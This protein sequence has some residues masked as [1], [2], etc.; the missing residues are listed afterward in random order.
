M[1]SKAAM[2]VEALCYKGGA[3]MLATACPRSVTS[4]LIVNR[5]RQ[6]G[7]SFNTII[8]GGA[9]I[10]QFARAAHV[11]YPQAT[12]LSFEPLPDVAEMLRAN[13]SDVREHRIFQ[14]ALGARDGETDFHRNSYNQSSSVL[15][16]LHNT[17][18]LLDGNKE[19]EHFKVSL[20][21]LDTALADV[22]LKSPVLLKLNLQG[23]ELEALRGAEVT[24]GN[25]DHIVLET[26]FEREYDGEP[27]FE[28]IWQ[29]LKE[30][31]FRFERPVNVSR[32]SSGNFVQMDA[33]FSR[34][35]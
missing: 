34:A 16:M 11:C 12:I 25:C 1:L 13:L 23:Y 17:G 35:S 2:V 33:L 32:G 27:L 9:N 6:L 14:S 31:D 5:L 10:G 8:D 26:V 21:R 24:L 20:A 30:R 28:E 29:F 3:K 18:G 19:V 7:P 15:P 4:W 22:D